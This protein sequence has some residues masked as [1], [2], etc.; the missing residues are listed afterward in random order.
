MSEL[1]FVE[2]THSYVY[3][4]VLVP[5]VTKILGDLTIMKRLD[6]ALLEAARDRGRRVHKAVHYFNEG[7]LDENTLDEADEPYLRAWKRFVAD[8]GFEWSWG[9]RALYSEKWGFAGT[10][11]CAGSWKRLRRRPRV[12]LDVKSG[13]SDPVHGPQTAAYLELARENDMIDK[14]DQSDRAVVR[15]QPNGFYQVDPMLDPADW[16]TFMAALTCYRFKER[17]GLL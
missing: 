12:L 3:E 4:G 11:D 13:V 7:N 8:Y 16:S 15:L 2:E 9:E 10:P 1:A 6:P 5:S 14:R 17:N